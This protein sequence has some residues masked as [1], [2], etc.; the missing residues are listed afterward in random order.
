LNKDKIF[1]IRLDPELFEQLNQQAGNSKK[2]ASEL[3]RDFIITGLQGNILDT[4]KDVM[5]QLVMMA[6]Q[7]AQKP[8][9]DRLSSMCA[10]STVSATAAL[11]MQMLYLRDV[12]ELNEDTVMD[13]YDLAKKEGLRYLRQGKIDTSA[14]GVDE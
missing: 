10:K 2:S 1:S 4:Q 14:L 13:F 5:T 6:V 11:F 12:M 9:E 3:A 8:L 7:Q